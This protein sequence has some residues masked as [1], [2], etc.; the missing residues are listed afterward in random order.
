MSVREDQLKDTPDDEPHDSHT[1]LFGDADEPYR[2]GFNLKTIWACLFVGFIMLPGSIYLSLVTGGQT[3]AADWVT[4]ILFLEIAKR[5]LVKMSRQEI[6]ILYWAAAG[7][8]AAGNAMNTGIT[9]GPFAHLIWEQYYKQAPEAAGIAAL[10]PTWVV[11][12]ISSEA[13]SQQSITW[14]L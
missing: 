4:V 2:S 10:I 8:A 14:R 5:S 12:A 13:L 3:G 11:P 9:G 1:A 6:M 7:L